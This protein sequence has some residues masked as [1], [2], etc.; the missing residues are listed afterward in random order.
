MGG[1]AFLFVEDVDTGDAEEAAEF[2]DETAGGEAA[3]GDG[4]E[5]VDLELGGGHVALFDG[6]RVED[7]EPR[8]FVGDRGD[9][10]AVDDAVGV[11]E[12]GLEVEP[13]GDSVFVAARDGDAEGVFEGHGRMFELIIDPVARRLDLSP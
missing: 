13:A 2:E 8:D 1:E 7:G 9:D 11:E 10:A 3:A 5:V 12:A 6:E 4:A